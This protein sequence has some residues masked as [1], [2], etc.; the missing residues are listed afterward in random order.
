[1]RKTKEERK[2]N[3]APVAEQAAAATK[4]CIVSAFVDGMNKNVRFAITRSL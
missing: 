3:K 1:M 2:Q 4:E